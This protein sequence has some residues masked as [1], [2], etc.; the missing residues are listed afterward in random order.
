MGLSGAKPGGLPL[1][2]KRTKDAKGN[3]PLEDPWRFQRLVGRLNYLTMTRPD[4]SFVVQSLINTSASKKS[5]MVVAVKVVRYLK[6]ESSFGLFIP[7]DSN[8]K[9]ECFY[10]FDWASCPM[11][12]RSVSG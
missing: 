2:I 5:H 6:Q 7:I 8:I 12:R 11:E 9:L 1:S 4:I 10:D 3:V